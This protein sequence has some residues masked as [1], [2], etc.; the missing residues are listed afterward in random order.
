MII[1]LLITRALSFCCWNYYC[2]PDSMKII[3]IDL[4][5]IYL[6]KFIIITIANDTIT[7]IYYGIIKTLKGKQR[8]HSF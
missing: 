1:E 3:V 6:N 8:T 4:A 2:H 5:S 7:H